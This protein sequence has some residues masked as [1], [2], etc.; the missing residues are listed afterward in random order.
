MSSLLL[1]FKAEPPAE[2]FA[3]AR[4]GA[5]RLEILRR[6]Y[7]RLKR[8]LRLELGK[9]PV[10]VTDLDAMGAV[11]VRGPPGTLKQTHAPR[12]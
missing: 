9:Y 5:Q 4:G 8:G 2:I 1:Q 6:F 10:E 12:G 3:Q 7:E 11:V